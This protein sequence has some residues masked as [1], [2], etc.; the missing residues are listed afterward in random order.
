MYCSLGY[1]RSTKRYE[2]GSMQMAF[3]TNDECRLKG[4]AMWSKAGYMCK[5]RLH[6]SWLYF[7]TVVDFAVIL[8]MLAI[9]PPLN[10]RSIKLTIAV[11]LFKVHLKGKSPWLYQSAQVE[12]SQTNYVNCTR[13]YMDCGSPCVYG[14]VFCAANNQNWVEALESSPL[15]F[16]RSSYYCTALRWRTL[17][18]GCTGGGAQKAESSAECK[19]ASQRSW[20]SHRLSWHKKFWRS[21]YYKALVLRMQIEALVDV[22]GVSKSRDGSVPYDVCIDLSAGHRK[23]ADF[24]FSV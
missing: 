23:N 2:T 19:A 12:A 21:R 20:E 16:G 18:H 4:P 8:L 9:A 7:C 3:E 1:R 10:N 11:P 5:Y 24:A 17:G 13:R 22:L 6:W 15:R 14:T